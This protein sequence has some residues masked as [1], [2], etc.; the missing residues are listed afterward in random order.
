MLKGYK[1]KAGDSMHMLWC[2]EPMHLST[3]TKKPTFS[4]ARWIYLSFL[5]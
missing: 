5:L 3:D 4:L 2:E 1:I